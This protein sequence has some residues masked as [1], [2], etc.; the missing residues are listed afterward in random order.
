M[1][2]RPGW[3]TVWATTYWFYLSV[4]H[5]TSAMTREEYAIRAAWYVVLAYCEEEG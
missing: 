3:T 4:A 5:P 2:M 1:N